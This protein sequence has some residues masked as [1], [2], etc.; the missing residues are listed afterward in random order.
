MDK[1]IIV[2]SALF[3]LLIAFGCVQTQKKGNAPNKIIPALPNATPSISPSASPNV[4]VDMCKS[5]GSDCY[6]SE[7]INKSDVEL[8]KNAGEFE[9]ECRAIISKNESFCK[10]YENESLRDRCYSSLAKKTNNGNYCLKI[11]P[12]DR[13][14]RADCLWNMAYQLKEDKVCNVITEN[15]S[16]SICEAIAHNSSE[17]CAGNESEKQTC[18]E[19]IAIVN[20]DKKMCE[21]LD[22]LHK[23][24]CEAVLRG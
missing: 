22:E 19:T 17:Y 23:I 16:K 6:E 15:L 13:A 18:M 12:A 7:A 4:S 10:K 24:E 9:N 2:V 11:P 20:K 5:M 3:L 21:N 8:C 1:R 14:N